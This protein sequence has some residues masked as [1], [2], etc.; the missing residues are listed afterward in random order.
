M[1]RTIIPTLVGQ[2]AKAARSLSDTTQDARQI[3][4]PSQAGQSG[5][6]GPRKLPKLPPRAKVAGCQAPSLIKRA[7]KEHEGRSPASSGTSAGD[8]LGGEQG[9][10]DSTNFIAPIRRKKPEKLGPRQS[11]Y[12][13]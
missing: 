4:L 7:V 11:E 5:E 1:E 10:Q 9:G 2:R 8:T 13:E 6:R 12:L 3:V